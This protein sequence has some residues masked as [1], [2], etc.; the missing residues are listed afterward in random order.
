VVQWLWQQGP[1]AQTLEPAMTAVHRALALND[2]LP[3]SHVN[4]GY[5]YLCQKQYDQARAEM[6]RAV[7]LAPSEAGSYAGLAQVLSCMGSTDEALEAA[8]TALRL[9]PELP[10]SHLADV[11][12]AYAA[13]GRYEEAVTSLQR[14][15]NRYPNILSAHLMLAG[16][17]SELGQ[18]AEART[19]AAEV[20]RLNPQ[21]SLAVHQQRVPIKD[22]AVLE[23]H[24]AALREAGLQ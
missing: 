9:Q 23:R 17:Y 11:G 19:E 13:A 3:A 20:L 2:R 7:V 12:S 6:E 10:D 5:I 15:L 18:V 14:Y 1:A 21:F 8:A 22:P 16:V 24:L 4:L